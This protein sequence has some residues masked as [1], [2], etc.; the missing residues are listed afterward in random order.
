M[1]AGLSLGLVVCLIA[2]GCTRQLA[3]SDTGYTGTWSRG[4]AHAKSI[5]AIAK[6]GD[7]YRFRWTKITREPGGLRRVKLEVRCGWDGTCTE[8][9]EGKK[10][11]EHSFRTWT[12][13]KSGHLMVEWH[14]R[15]LEPER[16]E[17]RTVDEL[18]VEPG[19][20]VLWSYT[21]ERDG[22]KFE[23][24]ARPKRFF[25]K[26]ADAVADPPPGAAS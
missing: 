8:W 19:G 2:A 15:R 25:H 1:R 7:E 5:V 18:V 21:I 17:S 24:E 13:P 14:E 16:R 20:R 9:L 12:D 23:G 10:I 11:A 4:P 6:V 3:V 26:V 22:Q